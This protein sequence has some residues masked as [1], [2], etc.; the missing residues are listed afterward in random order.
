M[1]IKCT[2]KLS[3][4][5]TQWLEKFKQIRMSTVLQSYLYAVA[6]ARLNQQNIRCGVIQIDG[7]EAGLFLIQEAH[8]FGYAIHALILDRGPLWFDDYGTDAH[9]AAFVAAFNR[10]FPRRFG[11]KRRFIPEVKNN[12]FVRNA[13]QQNGFRHRAGSEY[14]TYVLDLTPDITQLYQN[15]KKNWRGVL[16]KSEKSGLVLQWENTLEAFIWLVAAYGLDKKTKG[17]DGPSVSLLEALTNSFM[18]AG[19]MLIGC[20]YKNGKRIAGIMLLCH[21]RGATY[22]IGWTSGEGRAHGAHNMLLWK[23]VECLKNRG[24]LT[25]DL[26]GVQDETAKG[27]TKFK[28][29]MGGKLLELPG[30]YA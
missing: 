24:I 27:L 16:S 12:D 18:P 8:L 28:A 23:S 3:N 26:G 6:T 2:L 30:L 5:C 4:D 13:M 21:G 9:F 17:Y 19:D 22:Q 20:A 10:M 25:F 14:T 29:G 7:Q 15:L 1:S 11:R